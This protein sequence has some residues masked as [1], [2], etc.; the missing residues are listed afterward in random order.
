MPNTLEAIQ[1]LQKALEAG[2]YN[3]APS[4]LVQGAA[5]MVEDLSSVMQVVTYNEK[6]IKLQKD[7][8][9]ESC[10]STLAQFDRQLSV[11]IFGGFPCS[12][13]AGREF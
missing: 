2:S 8:P 10:K 7:L 6:S 1:S 3:V 4:N 12:G 5:L 11:G 9:V 13:A